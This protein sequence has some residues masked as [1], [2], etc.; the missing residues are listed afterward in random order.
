[1][2][3]FDQDWFS[4]ELLAQS[5]TWAAVIAVLSLVVLIAGLHLMRRGTGLPPRRQGAALPAGIARVERYELGAR[6]YHWGNFALMAAL[7]LSGA[8]L[9][10]PAIPGLSSSWISWLLIHEVSAGLFILGLIAHIVMAFLRA[11]ARSMWF[12]RADWS[13]AARDIRFYGTGRRVAGAPLGKF[14]VWQKLYH[15]LL[16][17]LALVSIVTGVSLFLSAE[18]LWTFDHAWLRWQRLLHQAAAIAFAGA[19]LGHVYVRLLRQHWPKLIAMFSGNLTRE[20][21]ER[22]HDA[23]RW[24][25]PRADASHEE[26]RAQHRRESRELPHG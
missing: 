3:R 14:D 11:D 15:A 22:E 10:E 4:T 19:I 2:L 9:F 23:H 25:P 12:R 8:A 13:D 24:Q 1:M 18:A 6:L 20:A 21:F 7:L 5:W 26:R 17:V 16:A